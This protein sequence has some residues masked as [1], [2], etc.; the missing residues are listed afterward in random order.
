M[1][2]RQKQKNASKDSNIQ[3]NMDKP[4]KT[5]HIKQAVSINQP[6]AINPNSKR[7]RRRQKQKANANPSNIKVENTQVV[8]KKETEIVEQTHQPS[9]LFY[10]EEPKRTPFSWA[11]LSKSDENKQ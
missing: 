1:P 4:V 8:T 7:R 9:L 2:N 11:N 10:S 5:D 3:K 6:T